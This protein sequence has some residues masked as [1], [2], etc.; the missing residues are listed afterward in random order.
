M[1]AHFIDIGQG[2][3]TLL[4]FP[5]GA[6][7]I[8]TGGELNDSF[9]SVAALRGY[10]DA[11]FER[12]ADLNGTL[13]LLV[14]SHPHIDHVRGVP[15]LLERYRIRNIIDNGQRRSSGAAEV[16]ALHEWLARHP[17]VRHEDIPAPRA[18][19][20]LT[21]DIIDPIRCSD[22]DPTFRVLWGQVD[23][24][25]GWPSDRFGK[26]P[27]DNENNHSIVLRVDFGRS[28]FL[29][30]GDLEDV[31]IDDLVHAYH[32]TGLLDV[33]VYKVGHHGSRNGSTA[34]EL[35]L[36]TPRIAVLSMGN[37]SRHWEWTAW[38]YGHPNRK[39]VELLERKVTDHRPS[40][41]VLVG[42]RREEF[43]SERVDRAIYGTGWDGTVVIEATT[44]GR[45][46]V[47]K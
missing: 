38:Q 10:L 44:K 43:S 31:A 4:E 27:F 11:F 18:R 22:V 3:A 32:D 47:L 13:D 40:R 46:R 34:A 25:P 15:M 20:G 26:R 37:S 36:M 24:D 30:P 41:E 9:D 12:R 17:E 19:A 1:R 42:E 23:G 6:A 5:C 29:F 28:S 45:L 2:D 7:L 16:V 21:D 33:D 8:D 39:A 35:G 14:L